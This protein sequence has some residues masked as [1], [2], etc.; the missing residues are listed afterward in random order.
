[1]SS[2]PFVTCSALALFAVGVVLLFDPAILG[3]MPPTATLIVAL[4]A[5]AVTGLAL[6]TWT[7][8]AGPIGGIYGRALTMGNFGHAF[9]GALS[10]VRP[11]LAAHGPVVWWGALALY[12][13]LATGWGYL[14]FW[15]SGLPRVVSPD[16]SLSR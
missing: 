8:R 13:A 9:I 16:P 12:A 3:A 6:A 14:L 10:L 7:G 15:S 5:A 4:Y 11:V 1:M 2:R